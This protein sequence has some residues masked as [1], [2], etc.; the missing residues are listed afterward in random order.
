[1]DAT[2]FF[3]FEQYISGLAKTNLLASAN[4]FHFCTCSGIESLQ[5]PLD[6]FCDRSAFICVDDT[7]DGAMFSG[8]GGGFYKKRTCTVFI[9]HRYEFRDMADRSKALNL[10]REVFRQLMSRMIVDESDLSNELI[11]LDT[12]NVLCR[13][14][15]QYF[16][17]GCTGLYFMIDVS[18]PVDLKYD[19]SQWQS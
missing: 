18:E 14:L 13:E 3:D 7:N 1:M 16:L 15:G 19:S 5:G 17:N 12:S 10:C 6:E 4:G 9:L 2:N 11:Y 8:R